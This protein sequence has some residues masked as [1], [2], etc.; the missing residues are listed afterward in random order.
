MAETAILTPKIHAP[1]LWC[2]ELPLENSCLA[3]DYIFWALLPLGG[4][5]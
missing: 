5:M 3:K 2:T 1:L 4:A